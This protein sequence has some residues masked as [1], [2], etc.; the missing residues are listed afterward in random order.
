MSSDSPAA[1]TR[2]S[3]WGD[4]LVVAGLLAGVLFAAA[5]ASERL[6]LDAGD[7][8]LFL[9]WG[10]RLAKEG[11]P[12]AD[13]GPLYA[14]WYG[15]LHLF[16]GDP[17]A[18]YFLNA[19]ILIALPGILLYAVLRLRCGVSVLSAGAAALLFAASALNV[20]VT[21]R[22]PQFGLLLILGTLL[23][24]DAVPSLPAALFVAATGAAAASYVRP[25]YFAVLGVLIAAGALA[26]FRSRRSLTATDAGVI[27]AANLASA[28]LLLTIGAP[29][30]GVRPVVAFGQHFAIHWI[31]WTHSPLDPWHDWRAVMTAAF[32][33]VVGPWGALASRPLLVVRHLAENLRHAGAGFDLLLPLATPALAIA[34]GAVTIVLFAR[35]MATR[36][37]DPPPAAPGRLPALLLPALAA[38]F[39]APSLASRVALYPRDHYLVVPF[40]L[41]FVLVGSLWRRPYR[42]PLLREALP[43]AVLAAA[44]PLLLVSPPVRDR[45]NLRTAL[46]LRELVPT[47]PVRVL[48][49]VGDFTPYLGPGA[50][51][52]A[53]I[54]VDSEKDVDLV[55]LRLDPA[56]A[57]RSEV[58]RSWRLLAADPP[59][60]FA[61]LTIPDTGVTAVVRKS[62]CG[63]RA[64]GDN[65][66]N[67]RRP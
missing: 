24:V 20:L 58:E 13:W 31:S 27:L 38:L 63:S 56:R 62:T 4:P 11:L 28:T 21:P 49:L 30:N 17:V 44:L 25:E 45:P 52:V 34:F 55:L 15:F 33:H 35:A 9:R 59:A 10:L 61:A 43:C 2:R 26:A 5:R 14:C 22:T 42:P 51:P 46:F 18:L 6:D 37:G 3:S 65:V 40:A 47:A 64:T 66:M 16:Q 29:M 57:P 19:T 36:E 23:A 41:A 54:G 53:E 48:G 60:G 12:Y 7:E 8:S 67:S 32:G 1:F 39:A 50:E